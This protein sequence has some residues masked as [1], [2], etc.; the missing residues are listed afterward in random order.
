MRATRTRGER[1]REREREREDASSLYSR[2]PQRGNNS[3]IKTE[4]KVYG[5]CIAMSSKRG[6]RERER[7]EEISVVERELSRALLRNEQTFVSRR[8]P[9]TTTATST[10]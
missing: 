8:S 4:L 2:D 5:E 6:R 1:E 3:E 7:V 10:S 9:S